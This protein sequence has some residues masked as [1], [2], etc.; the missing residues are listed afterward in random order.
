VI[1][2]A[3][4]RLWFIACNLLPFPSEPLVSLDD[5]HVFPPRGV[6]KT[7]L[8]ASIAAHDCIRCRESVTPHQAQHW[9]DTRIEVAYATQA[10]D[11][12]VDARD[13]GNGEQWRL[14]KLR[15][16]RRH[17][18]YRDYFAGSMSCPVPWRSLPQVD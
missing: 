15:L 12:L 3:L 6:A 7:M 2:K 14:E 9:W 10:W 16:L 11:L 18:G 5:L 13:D 8:G 4:L 1:L 17:L